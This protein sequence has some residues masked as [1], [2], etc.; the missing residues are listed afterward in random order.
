MNIIQRKQYWT[1]L[2]R[3]NNDGCDN[4]NKNKTYLVYSKTYSV[5][6][7]YHERKNKW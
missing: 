2:I 3:E 6:H 1:K 5:R 4:K 7:N